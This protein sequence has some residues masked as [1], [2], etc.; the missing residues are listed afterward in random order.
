M[1]QL[2]LNIASKSTVKIIAASAYNFRVELIEKIGN[3]DANEIINISKDLS[4]IFGNDLLLTKD[5]I[6]KY[7]SEETFPFIA[8]HKGEIIGFIIGV[9]LE[10]F[11][12]ES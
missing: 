2:T 6:L 11:K 8:R 1:E 5:N 10:N 3:E 12:Q 9:P 7:F 4:E